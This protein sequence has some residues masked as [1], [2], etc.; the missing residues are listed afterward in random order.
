[1][2]LIHLL[3]TGH[4]IVKY[5]KEYDEKWDDE[6]LLENIIKLNCS[7]RN[8]SSLP[9]LNNCKTLYCYNNQLTSLPDLENRIYQNDSY[10]TD[11]YYNWSN[12]CLP[13]EELDKWKCVW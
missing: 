13:F 7:C 3:R 4:C 11:G 9:A 6:T 8:L 12:N 10:L 2:D 1:M 5:N